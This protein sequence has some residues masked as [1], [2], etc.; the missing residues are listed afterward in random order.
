MA[1]ASFVTDTEQCCQ[2]F[3]WQFFQ[4]VLIDCKIYHSESPVRYNNMGLYGESWWPGTPLPEVHK[5]KLD[6]TIGV[7]IEHT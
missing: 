2:N 1:A 3:L 4:Y 5:N 6:N 7:L